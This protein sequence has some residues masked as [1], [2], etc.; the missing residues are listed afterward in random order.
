MRQFVSA[1]LLAALLAALAVP[2]RPYTLQYT[3]QSA[4][5]QIRW[6]SNTITVALSSSLSSPPPSIQATGA[7]VVLAARRALDRW[8]NAANID[9]NIVSSTAVEVSP[10]GSGGDGVSLITV[11]D[12]PNN[13]SLFGADTNAGLNPGR[14]RIF[15]SGGNIVE[16]DIAINP[17]P[18]RLNESGGSV[19][20]CFST[21]GAPGCYDLE[22]T[23]VHEIGHMLGL[24][25][26]GVV[27]ACM[28]PRQGTNGTFDLPYH[29]TRTL[30]S[31]DIAGARAIYGSRRGLGRIEGTVRYNSSTGQAAYGAHVWAEDVATGRVVAGNIALQSGFYRIDSLPPGQ[32][33]VLVEY[34]NEPVDRGQIGNSL[35]GGAYPQNALGGTTPFL[36]R[37]A[38]T[39]NVAEDAAAPLD[40]VVT[41]GVEPFN[42]RFIG[43]ITTTGAFKLSTVAVP[44]VPGRQTTVLVGGENLGVVSAA[45]V[46]SPFVTVTNLRTV[47]GFGIPVIAF[48]VTLNIRTP[49][50]EY[51]VLLQS[52]AGQVAYVS[53]GLTVDL[54]NGVVPGD[55]NL[56][57]NTVFFVAQHYRDFLSR[58]PDEAGLQFWV[59]TIE[60]CGSDAECRRVR[61]INVSAAFFLSIEFQETGY[62]VYRMYKAG[63][64]NPPGMPVPVRFTQFFAD[65]EQVRRGVIVGIGDWQQRLE[66]NKQQ[67]AQEFVQRPE[68]LARYP[69]GMS[70]AQFVDTLNQNAGGVLTA[71]QRNTLVTQLAE[72]PTSVQRRA[73]ALRAVAENENLKQ[74][75]FRNAFVLLQ[76]FGYLRRD[77]DD[78]PDPDYSGFQ[79]WLAQLNRFNGNFEQAELVKAFIESLEY[80]GRFGR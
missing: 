39:V 50:G 60:E 9:F 34:L 33:R 8:E 59:N 73:E 24:E 40:I 30:S 65:T 66:M 72:A 42:P 20:S 25:H 63:L 29:V 75:E 2:A 7:E 14:I 45:S 56:I 31:D 77:P 46:Q 35:T 43:Q 28:Q 10:T 54:P 4:T 69:A 51:S 11:A 3:D 52:V 79:F 58:E 62:L 27:G 36:S 80:R 23:F 78:A 18:T 22:S 44:L 17:A 70:A 16:A 38:G 67:F 19:P 48:D 47:T 13:R 5:T 64:G 68:F 32:Y 15:R 74:A 55:P 21:N 57:D 26:S 71:E 53:G 49:P 61:R 6:P 41:G 76:Y 37:Q 12:T 1:L